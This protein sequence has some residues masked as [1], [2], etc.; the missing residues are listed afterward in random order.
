MPGILGARDSVAIAIAAT[1]SIETG[2]P[3]IYIILF[4]LFFSD[5]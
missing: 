4:Q 5:I 2:L 3:V 1:E